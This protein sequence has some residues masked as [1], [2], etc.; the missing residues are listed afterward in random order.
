[1][2][3][4]ADADAQPARLR[5]DL[6]EGQQ[7]P[8]KQ[9]IH[10]L[11]TAYASMLL[12]SKVVR[13]SELVKDI[14]LKRSAVV[15]AITHWGQFIGYLVTSFDKA[16]DTVRDDDNHRPIDKLTDEQ[17]RFLE[18]FIKIMIPLVF[19]GSIHSSLGTEKLRSIY[20][21][22]IDDSSQYPTIIRLLTALLLV[23][24]SFLDRSDAASEMIKKV[25]KFTKASKSRF[26]IELICQKL[27]LVYNTPNIGDR[28]RALIER[29]YAE[30]QLRVHGVPTQSP[31]YGTQKS[32][33]VLH[34][35]K[36]S[37]EQDESEK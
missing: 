12:L 2:L 28:N 4:S 22:I 29:L 36:Q 32:G 16:V 25:D 3:D 11:S 17:K 24:V 18:H 5:G 1:M 8:S 10:D 21:E 27:L 13:N 26:M 34:M 19:S 20:E 15:Q 9:R 35:R 37:A 31:A 30:T 23:D 33:I 14:D 6:E 7:P